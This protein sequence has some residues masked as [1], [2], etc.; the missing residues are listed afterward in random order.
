M[1]LSINAI[2]IVF[3]VV[4]G[5]ALAALITII[6]LFSVSNVREEKHNKEI[7][8]LSNSLR[9]FVIDVANDKVRYFNSAHLRE[10]KTSSITSFYNQF[11]A[12][13]REELITWIGNLLEDDDETPR[14]IEV[15]VFIK[16][17]KQNATSIL[18]VQKI[19]YEKQLVYLESHLLQT[20]LYSKGKAEKLEF[21]K[22]DYLSK[23]IL[24]SNGRGATFAFN[25]FNKRTKKVYY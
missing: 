2:E 13:E 11:S 10:R 18:E 8:E 22:K 25:F 17:S 14:F 16:S 24:L 9:I 1:A 15:S 4:I 19:D 7:K 20:N 5:L 6:I 23:K 21:S 3:F 12:K